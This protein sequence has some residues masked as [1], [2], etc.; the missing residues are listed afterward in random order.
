MLHVF[1]T[2]WTTEL[3]NNN[4]DKPSSYCRGMQ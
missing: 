3:I 1:D 2:I 4:N